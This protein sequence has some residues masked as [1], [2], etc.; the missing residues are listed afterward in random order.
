MT[1]LVSEPTRGG[2]PLDMFLV[3]REELE[4]DVMVRGCLGNSNH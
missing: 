4:E 1:Q 3:N 2:A